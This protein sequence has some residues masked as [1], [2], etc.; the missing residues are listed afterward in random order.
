MGKSVQR[1]EGKRLVFLRAV[2]IEN[3]L[4]NGL[5]NLLTRLATSGNDYH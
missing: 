5:I 3:G 2:C 1:C 4:M